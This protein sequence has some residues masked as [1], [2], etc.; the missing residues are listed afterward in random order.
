[1]V[2]RVNR[3]MPTERSFT[4]SYV[5]RTA[6]VLVSVVLFILAWGVAAALYKFPVLFPGPKLVWERAIEIWQ[7]GSLSTDIVASLRR[8][9]MGFVLGSVIGV[10]LGLLAGSSRIVL[11]LLDPFI[12]FFRFVPPL[13]WFAPVLIWFG[14]GD[15]SKVVLIM[16]TSIFVVAVNTVGGV[17]SIPKDMLRMA[18][19]FGIGYGQRLLSI[20]L[21]ASVPYVIAGMRIAMGNAFMTVVTAEML[22]A[23]TG[24]GVLVNQALTLTDT[25]AVF[26]AIAILGLLGIIF[27]ALFV[28]LLRRFGSRFRA[29]GSVTA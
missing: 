24:L 12:Y 6:V 11:G 16:Y 22:G 15:A 21:P 8:I 23:S 18:G 10:L 28:Y 2:H 27:D 13:A 14:T 3:I 7:S 20:L 25:R 26:V 9:L 1:M 5:G 29:V 4:R 19:S 17:S